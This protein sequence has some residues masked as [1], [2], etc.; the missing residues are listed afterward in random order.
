MSSWFEFLAPFADGRIDIEED[1]EGRILGRDEAHS[2]LL[3][4]PESD[5]PAGSAI[6]W[7]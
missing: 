2:I 5:A 3:S 7:E 1:R 4:R 6:E